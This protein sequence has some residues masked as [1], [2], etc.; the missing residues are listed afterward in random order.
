MMEAILLQTICARG[1]VLK[2]CSANSLIKPQKTQ[3]MR[4][5]R[6]KALR[7]SQ[8]LTLTCKSNQMKN[9]AV[10]APDSV[11]TTPLLQIIVF[12][13]EVVINNSIKRFSV[14]HGEPNPVR[15]FQMDYVSVT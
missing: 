2:M 9:L 1:Q 4:G 11:P 8:V 5:P 12:A 10:Q 14:S 13:I 6:L 15:R 3:E 7:K